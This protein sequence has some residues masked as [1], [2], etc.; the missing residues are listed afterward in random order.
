MQLNIEKS[1]ISY[2]VVDFSYIIGIFQVSINFMLE[3]PIN[4]MYNSI[5]KNFRRF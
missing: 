1:T 2:C 4:L 3:K 5:V